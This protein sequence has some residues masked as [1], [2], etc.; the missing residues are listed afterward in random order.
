MVNTILANAYPDDKV[1]GEE[2]SAELAAPGNEELQSRVHSL[3]NEALGAELRYGDNAQWGI[4]PGRRREIQDI[5]EAID[6][7]N[8]EGGRSG[9]TFKSTKSHS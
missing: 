3:V 1:V 7:G 6:R 4:G 8:Y 5:F 2:D 9:S